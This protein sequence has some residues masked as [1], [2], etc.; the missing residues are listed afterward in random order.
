[1]SYSMKLLG[2]IVV[3]QCLLFSGLNELK[4]AAP[5]RSGI[6]TS[7]LLNDHQSAVTSPYNPLAGP[8]YPIVQDSYF[9]DDYGNILMI[10]NVLGEVNKPGQIVVREN[11]DF[12]TILALAGGVKSSA[13]LTKVIISRK[14]PDRNGKQAYKVNLKD[15]YNQGNRGEFIALKPNDTIIIPEKRGLSLDVLSRI[16]GIT[17]A[18]FDAYSVIR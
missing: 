5:Y 16:A 9:T 11:S 4:A 13:N 12:P 2:T 3:S 1:M 6:L 18:G 7:S 15:Y 8:N 17:L 10:I 14:E